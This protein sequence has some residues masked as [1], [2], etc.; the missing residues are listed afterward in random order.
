MLKHS[1]S[2]HNN[3]S[4]LKSTHRSQIQC[5]RYLCSKFLRLLKQIGRG[6]NGIYAYLHIGSKRCPG[7]GNGTFEDNDRNR[8][9][10]HGDP[11]GRYEPEF[12]YPGRRAAPRV[13]ETQRTRNRQTADTCSGNRQWIL[14]PPFAENVELGRGRRRELSDWLFA[15]NRLKVRKEREGMMTS[16]VSRPLFF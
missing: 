12:G 2:Q 6:C 7:S 13:T 11:R 1:Q 10:A 5:S 16:D 14:K 8:R 4:K 15:L 9:H 3:N